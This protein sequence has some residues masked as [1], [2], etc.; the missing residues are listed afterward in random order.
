MRQNLIPEIAISRRNQIVG[1][2]VDASPTSVPYSLEMYFRPTMAMCL[3]L[4]EW[5]VAA[6]IFERQRCNEEPHLE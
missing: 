6:Y 1:V 3:T 2:N 4:K 5:K